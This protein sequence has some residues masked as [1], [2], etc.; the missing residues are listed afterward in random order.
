MKT[1]LWYITIKQKIISTIEQDYI[2]DP[3]DFEW[4]RRFSYAFCEDIVQVVTPT[5]ENKAWLNRISE[6]LQRIN[7]LRAELKSV[8]DK[9][10]TVC[11]PSSNLKSFPYSC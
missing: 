8:A 5:G 2:E 9:P 1:F 11:P 7:E 10:A 4:E 6:S 3:V